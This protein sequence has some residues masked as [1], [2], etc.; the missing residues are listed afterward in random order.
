M[1]SPAVQTWLAAQGDFSVHFHGKVRVRQCTNWFGFQI[2]AR[3]S[4]T[5]PSLVFALSQL[6]EGTR[7]PVQ[8]GVRVDLDSG[9][10]W[11]VANQTGVIGWL[12]RDLWPNG[13]E[14]FPLLLRWE[15]EH[16]GRALIPR[17]QIGAEEWL[18]PSVLFPGEASFSAMTGHTLRGAEQHEVFSPGY[19]WCQDKLPQ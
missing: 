6:A 17:L 3:L 19:V 14:E 2:R 12:D 8:F 7:K 5:R 10:I 9:E 18:Y 1:K 13:E 15:V 11:D 4:L 16:T